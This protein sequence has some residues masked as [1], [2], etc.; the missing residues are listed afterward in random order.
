MEERFF[1]LLKKRMTGKVN[2][3]E[4]KELLELLHENEELKQVFTAIF[5]KGNEPTE[6]DMLETE[7][8]YASHSVKMQLNKLFDEEQ[9]EMINTVPVVSRSNRSRI[10]WAIAAVTG[11]CIGSIIYFY[12]NRP[13]AFRQLSQNNEIATRKGSKSK[14]ILPDSTVV[15]LNADSRITYPANF[16]GKKREVQLTGEAFFEVTKDAQRPFII[17]TNT[18]DIKVLGTVFNVRSYPEEAT[19]ETS[20]LKGEVEVTVLNQDN[21]KMILKPNEKLIVSNKIDMNVSSPVLLKKAHTKPV[22]QP[23]LTLDKLHFIEE[24]SIYSE[25]CWV[26]NKLRF[27][28]EQLDRLTSKIERWYNVEV[29]INNAKLKSTRFT[30]T[31]EK[32]S[33]NEVM[34]A[35]SLSY[36]FK[37]RMEN[38]KVIIY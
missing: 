28:A 38:A 23:L 34:E 24:D 32:E 37:Y 11:L 10:Y 14:I 4:E 19:T 7:Q 22:E 15:W 6:Q 36:S 8:A 2:P 13:G 29:I 9:E 20:L 21:K 27:D 18:I 12:L 26:D 35:L 16:Q 1:Y 31:F 25:T 3:Q 33:L 30:A 5:Q 17:H